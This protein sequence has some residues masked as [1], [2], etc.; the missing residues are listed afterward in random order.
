MGAF[1]NGRPQSAG[2]TGQPSW[3]AASRTWRRRPIRCSREVLSPGLP[4][5]AS[6]LPPPPPVGG[7]GGGGY[8]EE[9]T[10]LWRRQAGR[11]VAWEAWAV[12]AAKA[13]GDQ[14]PA[15]AADLSEGTQA[16]SASTPVA[17]TSGS[18]TTPRERSASSPSSPKVLPRRPRQRWRAPPRMA[19]RGIPRSVASPSRE[20]L[21][22]P[23]AT[24]ATRSSRRVYSTRPR[25]IRSP[26][27][28]T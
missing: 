20:R 3:R 23:C 11:L 8:G 5:R 22:T 17:T 4:P 18:R 9:D 7:Y 28:P 6:Q 25:Y 21:S 1:S 10:A 12:G 13:T 15:A 24:L 19:R 14:N 26:P 2:G 27:C 16:T